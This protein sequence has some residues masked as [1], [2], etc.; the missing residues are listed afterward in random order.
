MFRLVLLTQSRRFSQNFFKLSFLFSVSE[1]VLTS[2]SLG[3]LVN[4]NL[5]VCSFSRHPGLHQRQLRAG[6]LPQRG[7]GHAEVG[8]HGPERGRGA[9]E[10][11]PH[12][13]QPGR[14]P[15]AE[16][17]TSRG[18]FSTCEGIFF[19]M[20]AW[21]CCK[22]VCLHQQQNSNNP[23]NS[24]SVNQ[25]LTHLTYSRTAEADSST[26]TQISKL[27]LSGYSLSC[28]MFQILSHQGDT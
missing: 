7:G 8:A 23:P 4:N 21:L 10:R 1:N 2:L 9:A 3:Y 28:Q 15:Q 11:I 19:G 14:M 20:L 5:G 6:S 22:N 13:V 18:H 16:P 25:G 27:L 24:A 26:L 12:A 17:T